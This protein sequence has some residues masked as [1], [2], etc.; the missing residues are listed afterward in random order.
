MLFVVALVTVPVQCG[1]GEWVS[2]SKQD[3]KKGIVLAALNYYITIPVL[4]GCYDVWYK[5]NLINSGNY[6]TIEFRIVPDDIVIP[7]EHIITD[8]KLYV[9]P[10]RY[11][12]VVEKVHRAL[13]EKK[14]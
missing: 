2:N 12:A 6:R 14:Q 3:I 11:N 13:A 8:V 10:E 9:T 4:K 7:G 1:F 5:H